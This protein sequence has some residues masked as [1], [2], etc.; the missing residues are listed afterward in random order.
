MVEMSPAN[1]RN[2]FRAP[3]WHPFDNPAPRRY[4]VVYGEYHIS[5]AAVPR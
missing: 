4:T 1:R 5:V 3:D 2:P